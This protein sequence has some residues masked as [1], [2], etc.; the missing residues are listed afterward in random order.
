MA[1]THHP[2]SWPVSKVRSTFIDFFK[3]KPGVGAAGH[4]FVA[5]S[6]VVPHD[7]PTLL[8]TNAGMNQFKPIF[9]GQAA[10]GTELGKLKRAVNSQKCIRAG[11][12]HNDLEDVGKDTYHHTFFEML[13]N[14]SF[15][16]YFKKEA[17]EWSW[18]L[19]TKVYG[20]P[21]ASLYATYFGGSPEAGLEPDLETKALWEKL[22]PPERVL[23]GNMKDNFWEMGETGPCGPCT[24][25]HVDRLT[26][27]GL[28]GPHG[29]HAPQLVNAGDPDLIEIWNNVFIQF[30]R[31]EG[32]ALRP[33]PARHV[34][35]GMGL[36]RL[37][38]I[39]QNKRS[40]YDTDV[41][42]P[43][44]AE[45]ERLTGA[46]AYTGRLGPADEG[47]I[48]TAYR[49]IADHIRTL[50]FAITDGA[51]PSNEGRGY[52]LR[53]ILRRAVRYGR[54]M[55]GAK[56]GFFYQLVP[57]IVRHMSD[58][59]PEL[60][61]N[62]QRV[63]DVIRGEEE[64][65]GKTLDKGIDRCA[66]DMLW[67]LHLQVQSEAK[68]RPNDRYYLDFGVLT[69]ENP[70]ETEAHPIK[71]H[72]KRNSEIRVYHN[73]GSGP[74]QLPK[75]FTY[76]TLTAELVKSIT[77]SPPTVAA[78]DIFMLYD[79]YGFPVDL[80]QQMAEE[81]GMRV[82]LAG[83]EQ[84]MEQQRDRARAAG[85]FSGGSGSL[86]LGADQTAQ[87][88]RMHVAPTDD[89]F[90]FTPKDVTARV[91]AIWDGHTF[92]QSV[93]AG[94]VGIHKQIGVV[95]SRTNFYSEMG[96][97]ECDMG[98]IHVVSESRSSVHDDHDKGDFKVE[99]VVAFAGYVLHI[100]SITRGE[101]RVGDECQVS[102]ERHRRA[103]VASNH[104]ATHLLNLAMRDALGEG[105]DQKGSLVAED[106]LRF[107]FSFSR[108]VT[109]EE[110]LRIERGVRDR[111]RAALPVYA[112]PVPQ[113]AARG[114]AG[115]RA[116]FGEAYPD[117]VRVVAVGVSVDELLGAPE[118]EEW[119]TY[120]IEFCGGTHVESTK[121]I[122][123]FVLT[124][125][126]GIAKG[127]RR[128]SALTGVAAVAAIKSA[129]AIADRIRGAAGLSAEE[130]PAEVTQIGSSIDQMTL[131]AGRKHELREAL[132]G[133]Q[134]R[135]KNSQ[136]EAAAG[137]ANHAARLGRQIAEAAQ[138]SLTDII[139]NTI[140][141]GGDRKALQSAL[142][143][144]QAICPRSA[145]MLFAAD[146]AEGKINIMAAV[147]PAM[148]KRGLSAGD[149]VRVAAEACGGK[150]GGKPD[151]AQGGGSDLSRLRD[152]ISAA[153]SLAHQKM[154]A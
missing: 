51:V 3:N 19:L 79:T 122:G 21:V 44:F 73:T 114:I 93:R 56:P 48:D 151:A 143:T 38:S 130:L 41:F 64:S 81:R 141:V 31:E 98:R 82:D 125:E 150:G 77:L 67:A 85:K 22:L 52:V 106:R 11:G 76:E 35:T 112:Q 121:D 138:A 43:I 95:L 34:D 46:V 119:R 131:P 14:W 4:T 142:S 26:A 120:S 97:Q 110:I 20:I 39:L 49:V 57:V 55:L 53:R 70:G 10:P 2:A 9:L 153:T 36:E 100:G 72:L 60:A 50:T 109:P 86:A 133:L 123:E 144:I 152:A 25:I 145:V 66:A 5:S 115:L 148:V 104:T 136:K 154:G 116:V 54:Q 139:I 124:A 6:P 99:S 146:E 94:S 61:R 102:I 65:F 37:T 32:G 42:F 101:I 28:A 107:D 24:E 140:D 127:V 91:E 27:M 68:S 17:V 33:L 62:P 59:F 117:P 118:R 58:A 103:A 8:F 7:D 12:K 84:L 92:E 113:A 1:S 78:A 30:N 13:G 75:T 90:K 111:V 63:M 89:H 105:V 29:R 149:W 15:G 74:K 45:I 47:N 69:V 147:P 80:T 23:P 40:N 71:S 83:F 108:P 129:D 96:G 135:V 132:A 87:L 18:E 16:D 137:R 88:A 126:E 128:F 134:E